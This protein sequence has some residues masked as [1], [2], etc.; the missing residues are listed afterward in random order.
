MGKFFNKL[1]KSY[2]AFIESM[3][4]NGYTFDSWDECRSKSSIASS[5]SVYDR[6]EKYHKPYETKES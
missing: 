2:V 3:N 1:K 4:Y 6:Y 5:N